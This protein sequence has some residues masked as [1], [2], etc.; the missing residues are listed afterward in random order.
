MQFTTMIA[1]VDVPGS[2]GAKSLSG[3]TSKSMFSPDYPRANRA[4]PRVRL[5]LLVEPCGFAQRAKPTVITLL[6]KRHFTAVLPV[7]EP[8][9][10]AWRINSAGAGLRSP[11]RTAYLGVVK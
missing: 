6:P 5:D 1:V 9:V 3:S 11:L 7:C 4:T 10:S 8:Q 2:K